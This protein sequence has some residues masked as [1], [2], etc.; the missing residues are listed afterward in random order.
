MQTSDSTCRKNSNHL[1]RQWH[2]LDANIYMLPYMPMAERVV[3][4][5]PKNQSVNYY[6]I[7]QEKASRCNKCNF[8]L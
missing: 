5:V 2:K 4:S 7:A 6:N 8:F 3:F 1:K